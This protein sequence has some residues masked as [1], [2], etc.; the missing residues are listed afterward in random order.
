MAYQFLQGAIKNRSSPIGW[1]LTDY[2]FDELITLILIRTKDKTKAIFTGKSLLDSETI[3]L[4][5]L[6]PETLD[7]SWVLFM[8]YRDKLWSFTDCT[9]MTFMRDN[10]ISKVATFDTHF[11]EAGLIAV[12]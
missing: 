8:K 7:R 5:Y 3:Q 1:I 12:P 4:F 2:I 10:R 11:K 6:K 9:S